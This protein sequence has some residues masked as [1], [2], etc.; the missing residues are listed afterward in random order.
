[1]STSTPKCAGVPA[2]FGP[3]KPG[4][5]A[6]IDHH[7]RVVFLR[8]C[9]D[10]GQ[11]GQIPVHAE[12]A[13]RRDHDK[14]RTLF[15]GQLQLPSRS[16]MSEFAKRYRFALHRRIPSMIEAW[17]RASETIASSGP[18]S[19]SNKP[20]LASKQAANR[21]ESSLPRK[22]ASAV[23]ARGECLACRR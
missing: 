3:M 8:Q 15:A 4:G 7:Q 2:P 20:P 23:P 18:N 6:V 10:L 17:F 14:A 22:L 1:M 11:L 19:G 21:I 13:V 9:G 5:V 12:N 16:F